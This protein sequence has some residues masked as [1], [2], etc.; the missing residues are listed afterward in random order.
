MQQTNL[1]LVKILAYRSDPGRGNI[2][3]IYKVL[4]EVEGENTAYI[5]EKWEEESNI[6]MHME[7]WEKIISQQWKSTSALTW[8]EFGW[9]NIAQ[10]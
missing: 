4:Q 6:M 5:K 9:K 10:T 1:R 3:K 2:S 7:T 8:R